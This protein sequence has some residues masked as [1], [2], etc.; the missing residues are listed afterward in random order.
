MIGPE[1][2]EEAMNDL[3]EF[4]RK[5]HEAMASAHP[6]VEEMLGFLKDHE[7][8][9]ALFTGKGRRTTSITLEAL[10]LGGYF[11]FTVS[12]TDVVHHKPHP[13]GIER[14]L[15]AFSLAP[16]Q[17]LMVGDGLAD[18]KA[19]RAAGVSMA[20]A[21]WDCYDRKRVLEAKSEYVFW[22]V[23]EL[24]GWFRQQYS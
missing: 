5:H 13:E 22:E 21:V 2:V 10:H 15:A 1:P 17:V 4:Y 9:L 14:A 6:G 7:V 8:K 12:G 3:C 20:A 18:I 11:D 19:S 16:H 23:F 24:L